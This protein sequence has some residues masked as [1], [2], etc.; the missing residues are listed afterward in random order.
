MLRS[1]KE[2]PLAFNEVNAGSNPVRSARLEDTMTIPPELSDRLGTADCD[3]NPIRSLHIIKH[4]P[5]I[6]VD[7]DGTL[8]NQSHRQY[9]IEGPKKDWDAFY[10][11]CHLDMPHNHIGVIVNRLADVY[12]IILMSGRVERVRGKTEHW[13]NRHFIRYHDLHMRPDG[14][15]RP[16]DVLKEE[17]LDRDILPFWHVVMAF[18]DRDRIVKMWRRRGIP[19]L[20]VAEGDF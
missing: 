20:Q 12:R 17:I 13:L 4:P 9:L 7:I 6:I 5:A 16:D 3:V 1:S 10:E 8:S 11:Q 15:Y 14:D 18:D 19:C 2:G